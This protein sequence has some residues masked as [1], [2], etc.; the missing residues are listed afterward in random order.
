MASLDDWNKKFGGA[1]GMDPFANDKGKRGFDFRL[2]VA[3]LSHLKKATLVR[4]QRGD[5]QIRLLFGILAHDSD[6]APEIGE[7]LEHITL[8]WQESDKNMQRDTR[9]RVLRMRVDTLKRI[10]SAAIPSQYAPY[11]KTD[12]DP[13]TNKK[14]YLDFTGQPLTNGRYEERQ[15]D[16]NE[17]L[18]ILLEGLKD[19]LANEGGEL[20]ELAG[21]F[22]YLHKKPNARNADYP[23]TNYYVNRPEK[24][25]VFS[26][27]ETV[28]TPF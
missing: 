15:Q 5:E 18:M 17:K 25:P 1:E 19:N 16:I 12:A 24:L 27:G 26:G 23:Y 7:S 9:E 2:D 28:E 20:E 6:D 11:D 22:L 8:P 10:Y 14:R 21:T 3:Y 4:S 13:A